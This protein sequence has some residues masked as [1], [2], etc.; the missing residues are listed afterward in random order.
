[1]CK[2]RTLSSNADS[3]TTVAPPACLSLPSPRLANAHV[4]LLALF[5]AAIVKE[6]GSRVRA[7]F[8]IIY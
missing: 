2:D 3:S 5:L 6:G 7:S 1:M 4:A 8:S